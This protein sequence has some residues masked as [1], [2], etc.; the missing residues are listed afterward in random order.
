[1]SSR[2][3]CNNAAWWNSDSPNSWYACADV[4]WSGTAS[5]VSNEEKHVRVEVFAVVRIDK[6]R[7]EEKMRGSLWQIRQLKLADDNIDMFSEPMSRVQTV[8]TVA[9]EEK[10]TSG[11]DLWIGNE[12]NREEEKV[13]RGS[14]EK[15]PT[16]IYSNLW[17]NTKKIKHCAKSGSSSD[18]ID[19]TL[20]SMCSRNQCQGS[21]GSDLGICP[22]FPQ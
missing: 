12:K 3:D 4:H 18:E 7:V 16:V 11:R 6:D 9:N 15:V 5:S 21:E 14:W 20:A 2:T 19:L 13:M 17:S 1:M 22:E 10:H 8:S